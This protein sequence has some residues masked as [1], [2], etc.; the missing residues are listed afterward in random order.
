MTKV[1]GCPLCDAAGGRVV[2]Q[3][4]KWRLVHAEEAGF[5][6]FYRVVWQEHVREFSQ[7]SA[8]DRS[9]CMD[10]VVA[11]EQALIAQL[12]PAKVN[13]ASLGNAVPHLHWHVVARFAWDSHFPGA[14]WAPAQRDADPAR[15]AE[16]VAQLPTLEDRLRR[17]LTRTP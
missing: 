7:L 11:V 4:P 15:L 3:A 14:V 5:P 17:G 10:V 1:A 12:Q 6:A 16:V 13:V 9:D 8:A 2:V